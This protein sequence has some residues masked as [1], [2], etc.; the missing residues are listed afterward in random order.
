M[1]LI[2]DVSG[3]LVVMHFLIL[4]L[5]LLFVLVLVLRVLDLVCFDFLFLPLFLWRLDLILSF[6][7]L[8]RMSLRLHRF[9]T[10]WVFRAATLFFITGGDHIQKLIFVIKF[11]SAPGV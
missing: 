2:P 4:A 11:L 6:H 8:G 7:F 1:I 3:V 9:V 10:V 5:L